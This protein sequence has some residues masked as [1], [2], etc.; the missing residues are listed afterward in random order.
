VGAAAEAV[1]AEPPARGQ[2]GALER[3][4]DDDACAQQGC[5]L[6]VGVTPGIGV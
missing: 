2:G 4:V 3:P 6:G 1:Q 5:E